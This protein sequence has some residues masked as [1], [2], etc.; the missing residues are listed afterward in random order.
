[1]SW[2]KVRPSASASFARMVVEGTASLRSIFEII[3]R[4]TPD[5]SANCSSDK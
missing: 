3:D 1:M 2:E 4:L 5:S